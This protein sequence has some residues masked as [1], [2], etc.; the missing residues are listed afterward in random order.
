MTIHPHLCFRGDCAQFGLPDPELPQLGQLQEEIDS[1]DRM[2]AL[3]DQFYS[4]LEELTQ[5]DWLS[6]RLASALN[7]CSLCYLLCQVI[8][9]RMTCP[10]AWKHVCESVIQWPIWQRVV[11]GL[12]IYM[13]PETL[14]C[15]KIAKLKVPNI[16][17]NANYSLPAQ[18]HIWECNAQGCE[19]LWL[20][21]WIKP[22]FLKVHSNLMCI[23]MRTRPKRILSGLDVHWSHSHCFLTFVGIGHHMLQSYT[24]IIQNDQPSNWPVLCSNSL[25]HS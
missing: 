21:R 4:G 16:L 24:T 15:V 6:F 13:L 9:V 10:S 1:H 18:D 14:Q 23:S 5:Q 2:W 12:W 7:F 11:G 20:I 8:F 19:L 22:S 3:Y 17:S 25:S